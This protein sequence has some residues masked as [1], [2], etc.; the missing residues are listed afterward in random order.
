MIIQRMLLGRGDSTAGME[1]WDLGY[2]IAEDAPV[3]FI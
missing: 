2:T 3:K 1:S